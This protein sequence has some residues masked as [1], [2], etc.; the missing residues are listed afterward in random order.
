MA[1][2]RLADYRRNPT[3]A[4]PAHEVLKRLSKKS[5]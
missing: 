1:E 5:R 3:R 2:Q 4:R